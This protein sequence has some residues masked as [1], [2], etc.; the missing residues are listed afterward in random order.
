MKDVVIDILYEAFY[1]NGS[2]NFVVKQDKRKNQRIRTLLAYSYH[3]GQ[4]FGKIILSDDRKAAAILIDPKK[5]KFT[6]WDVK[7]MFRVIGL[8]NVIKVL[9][10]EKNLKQHCPKSDFMYLWYV[11]VKKE[12]QGKGIGTKMIQ[13]ILAS[14]GG[15]VIHL[16]TS[17]PRN[18]KLYE[19]LGFH[20]DGT[21]Q[22][23]AYTVKIY[24]WWPSK[25]QS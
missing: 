16:Q 14:A 9:K 15:K 8:R 22:Q 6:L 2:V 21:Y 24:S 7:L 12:D 11:G 5:E 19:Q 20:C 1:D 17:N 25:S 3:K 18:F 23:E 10:R 13:E 4:K